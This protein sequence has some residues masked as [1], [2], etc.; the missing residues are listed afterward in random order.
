MC[1]IPEDVITEAMGALADLYSSPCWEEASE[2]DRH[3]EQFKG[4]LAKSKD[5]TK[6]IESLLAGIRE[7]A[8]EKTRAA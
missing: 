3:A 6:D 2:N 5:L 7:I 1:V 8:N 4:V